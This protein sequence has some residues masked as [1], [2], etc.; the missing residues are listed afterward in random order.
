MSKTNLI[1]EN[2]TGMAAL[3]RKAPY[4]MM[5]VSGNG[6]PTHA[7]EAG[8]KILE[9]WR[10]NEGDWLPEPLRR[11][12]Q[13]THRTRRQSAVAVE[14]DKQFYSFT[15][16]P[17]AHSELYVYGEEIS[18]ITSHERTHQ[19]HAEEIAAISKEL[20]LFTYSVSHDL[21]NPLHT[22]LI[23]IDLLTSE[24]SESLGKD[25][26][27]YLRHIE[28]SCNTLNSLIEEI[29]ILSRI[30]RQELNIQT[31]DLGA[32]AQAS[33]RER[34]RIQSGRDITLTIGEDLHVQGD[35]ALL[36]IAIDNLIGNAAKFTAA[37]TEPRIE[38]GSYCQ[39]GQ[40]IFYVRDNGIG[41]DMNHADE[42][43][44][45]FKKLHSESDS[46]GIGVGLAKVKRIVARH[47]GS[48]WAQSAV[49]TGSTFFFTL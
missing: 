33:L 16:V 31:L 45:P 28:H 34:E 18:A 49:D 6:E 19:Q 8:L 12:I 43:F 10:D 17:A 39:E 11:E 30:S 37:K 44:M 32:L 42:I 47:G 14:C 3:A 41:F 46:P 29:L 22:M 15:I 1:P 40:R 36:T 5:T 25:G 4:P 9:A 13:N 35:E 23:F 21:R 48:V 24:C 27:D 38:F 7:N 26:R 20:D 2:E